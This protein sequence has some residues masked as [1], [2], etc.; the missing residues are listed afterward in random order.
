[1]DTRDHRGVV[2]ALL[3][4]RIGITYSI[5]REWED[6]LGVDHHNSERICSTLTATV[7]RFRDHQPDE[8][9][10]FAAYIELTSTRTPDVSHGRRHIGFGCSAERRSLYPY[11]TAGCTATCDMRY[12]DEKFAGDGNY[13]MPIPDKLSNL[14]SMAATGQALPSVGS[15]EVEIL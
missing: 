3:A 8:K 12:M 1:M 15:I 11:S 9:L 10:T 4:S 13:K 2:G 7:E 5:E 14:Q 6:R